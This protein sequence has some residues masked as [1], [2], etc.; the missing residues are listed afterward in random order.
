MQCVG[1]PR[2][3]VLFKRSDYLKE[4]KARHFA[5][6]DITLKYALPES[7]LTTHG[8]LELSLCKVE[9]GL[10]PIETRGQQTMHPLTVT[11]VGT[12]TAWT[13]AATSTEEA[14]AWVAA[15]K[16]AAGEA[17]RAMVRSA[18]D[19]NTPRHD[20]GRTAIAPREVERAPIATNASPK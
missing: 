9:R 10:A 16:L 8:T 19:A 12:K 6:E 4:W 7:P 14:D 17:T 18:R 13:L 2:L 15:L 5:L 20:V 3:G 1:K 11:K